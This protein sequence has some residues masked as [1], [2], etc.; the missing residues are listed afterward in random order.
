MKR[1]SEQKK[2]LVGSIEA[3]S[4]SFIL[5]ASPSGVK[6]NIPKSHIE[7]RIGNEFMLDVSTKDI[8]RYRF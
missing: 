6:Y 1:R 7:R 8:Q 4:D 5:V 2:T 3:I